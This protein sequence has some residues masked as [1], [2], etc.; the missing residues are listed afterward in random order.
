M[1]SG[2]PILA[3]SKEIGLQ[4]KL[5]LHACHQVRVA[6]EAVSMSFRFEILPHVDLVGKVWLVWKERMG[7]VCPV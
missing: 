6:K 4:Q 3:Q 7:Y 1:Y 5:R 2:R